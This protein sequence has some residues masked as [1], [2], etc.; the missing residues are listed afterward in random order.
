LEKDTQV[1]ANAIG[2]GHPDTGLS[3]GEAVKLANEDMNKAREKMLWE[4]HGIR[5]ERR[6]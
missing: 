3:M 4:E 6:A 1:Q 2:Y 5:P